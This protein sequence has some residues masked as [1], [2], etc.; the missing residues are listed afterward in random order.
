[1]IEENEASLL[2]MLAQLGSLPL[3]PEFDTRIAAVIARLP[4]IG[5]VRVY[6]SGPPFPAVDEGW[7]RIPLAGRSD[8]HGAIDILVVD[9]AVFAGNEVSLLAA[10][11]LLVRDLDHRL[12][13]ADLNRRQAMLED[14]HRCRRDALE[15]TCRKLERLTQAHLVRNEGNMAFLRNISHELRTPLN[16]IRGFSEML[17]ALEIPDSGRRWSYLEAVCEGAGRMT[18]MLDQMLDLALLTSGTSPLVEGEINIGDLTHEIFRELQSSAGERGVT[19]SFL[20]DKT[21]RLRGDREALAVILTNILGNAIKFSPVSGAVSLTTTCDADGMTLAIQDQGPGVPEDVSE[22]LDAP[23][24]QAPDVRH[25][26]Q[27]ACLGLP[28]ARALIVLHGGELSICSG[29]EGG[30]SVHVHL[31][32]ERCFPDSVPGAG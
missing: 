26:L 24:E 5:K 29:P 15:D 21:L 27:G 25:P 28:V 16:A 2:D 9:D 1:M 32:V 8:L 12:L 20:G 18:A 17:L 13:E 6:T 3:G 22:W 30:A 11:T 19:L 31:P 4:G 14:E 23:F 7:R 10:A